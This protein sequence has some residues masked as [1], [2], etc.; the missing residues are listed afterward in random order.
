MTTSTA[1]PNRRGVLLLGVIFSVALIAVGVLWIIARMAETTEQR[2]FAFTPTGNRVAVD[3][4]AGDVDVT[5]SPDRQVHVR[6]QARFGFARPTFREELT[7]TGLVLD[8]DCTWWFSPCRVDYVIAVPPDMAGDVKTS[9]GRVSARD[10][11]GDVVLRTSAGSIDVDDVSGSLRLDTSAGSVT[12]DR[13]GSGTVQVDTSAGSVDLTFAN[14]PDRVD[15]RTSAGSIDVLLPGDAT[16][17][18]QHQASAGSSDI[19][20]STDPAS[21]HR[22]NLRTSAGSIDVRA[23]G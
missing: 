13:I 16:Y 2:S 12:G 21:A 6:R 10:L 22:L 20:V 23:G 4:P 15:V 1:S 18:I 7:P 17:A 3:S 14:A 11:T 19:G 5:A 9:A 8:A